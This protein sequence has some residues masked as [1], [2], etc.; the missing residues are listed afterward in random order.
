M[1]MEIFSPFYF[2]KYPAVVT[3]PL[4]NTARGERTFTLD[5]VNFKQ[6]I[7]SGWANYYLSVPTF[8]Y[9]SI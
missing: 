4:N 1:I 7:P 5:K 8:P 2:Q 9:Q 6:R 3:D